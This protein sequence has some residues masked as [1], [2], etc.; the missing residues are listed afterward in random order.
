MTSFKYIV[1]LA[2]VCRPTYAL[3]YHMQVGKTRTRKDIMEGW[4]MEG[5]TYQPGLLEMLK[6]ARTPE[7]RIFRVIL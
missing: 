7:V 5:N 4:M 3:T 1:V 6:A 2:L